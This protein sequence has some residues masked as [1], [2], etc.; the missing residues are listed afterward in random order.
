[1]SG[2]WTKYQERKRKLAAGVASDLVRNNQKHYRIGR[3][4]VVAGMG[5]LF[6]TEYLSSYPIIAKIILAISSLS[7]FGGAVMLGFARYERAVI[8]E[9]DPEKPPPAWDNWDVHH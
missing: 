5:P 6:L 8:D 9:P 2:Y 7:M 3:A 4:L 1:M